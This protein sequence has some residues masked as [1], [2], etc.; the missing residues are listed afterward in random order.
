MKYRDYFIETDGKGKYRAHK[1]YF[2]IETTGFL[3][4][5]KK[6]KVGKI[7]WAGEQCCY[8]DEFAALYEPILYD[9][10]EEVKAQ[11]DFIE[12]GWRQPESQS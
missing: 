8:A 6:K 12:D 3:W 11:I 7:K 5:R 1:R 10:I 9:S 4:W 2:E